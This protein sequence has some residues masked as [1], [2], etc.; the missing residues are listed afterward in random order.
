MEKQGQS[1]H[2]WGSVPTRLQQPGL[3]TG[4]NLGTKN[5]LEFSFRSSRSESSLWLSGPATTRS[6]I[7]ELQ[8]AS[9]PKS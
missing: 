8:P 6:P 4:P 2:F 9:E 3:G 7:Q 1:N 5:E